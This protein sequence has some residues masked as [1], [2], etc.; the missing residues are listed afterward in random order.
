M[1]NKDIK[2]TIDKGTK[3]FKVLLIS[4]IIDWIVMALMFIYFRGC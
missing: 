1:N 3:W 4:R 2:K